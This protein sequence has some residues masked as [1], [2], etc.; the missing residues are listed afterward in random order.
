MRIIL[1][2]SVQPE[3]PKKSS[4]DLYYDYAIQYTCNSHHP[5][6]SPSGWVGEVRETITRTLNPRKQRALSIVWT[7]SS[8]HFSPGIVERTKRELA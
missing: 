8:P 4:I 6:P 3:F 5:Y 2:E 1:D 7:M